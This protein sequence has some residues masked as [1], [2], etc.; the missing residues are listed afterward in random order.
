MTKKMLIVN[1]NINYHIGGYLVYARFCRR[2][3][4]AGMNDLLA[5]SIYC[6]SKYDVFLLVCQMILL[7][8]IFD[9]KWNHFMYILKLSRKKYI[10]Q[11]FG[12]KIS[13]PMLFPKNT[14]PRQTKEPYRT[15]R[16]WR[17]RTTRP[18]LHTPVCEPM[19]YEMTEL[20]CHIPMTLLMLPLFQI[21]L[22]EGLRKRIN[23][24]VSQNVS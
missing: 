8:T 20:S 6:Q 15:R 22:F 24:L 10:Q 12:C 16:Y 18:W 17:R 19:L 2:Y 1:N 5:N 11:N 23:F 3:K 7:R 4:S 9:T 13:H 14:F 21:I